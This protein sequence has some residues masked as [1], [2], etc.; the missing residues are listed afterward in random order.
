MDRVRTAEMS[1]RQVDEAI[2]RGAAAILPL[3]S[4]E[5]HGPHAATGDYLI[6]EEV[7]VRAARRSGDVVF[8]CLPFGYSEYFRHFP[9]TVTLQSETL[10]RVVQDVVCC[11]MD[12]GF[13]H[14]V[15]LNGHKGNEPALGDLIRKLRRD[16]GLLVPVASPLGLGLTP[17]LT[18]E[19]YGE[20]KIGHGGE[21]M[22]SLWMYLFPGTVD[23]SLAEDWG[24]LDFLGLDPSG[25]AGVR[26][27]GCEVRFA[28][29]MDDITPPSG[30]LSNPLLASA[31]RGE[32]IV[33]QAVGRLV[34][35]MEW[36][37]GVDPR[38]EPG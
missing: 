14:I 4:T 30:S 19:L 27:E 28:V 24:T 26:F 12:Q 6:A 11:L 15:I 37:K 33:D 36:F 13:S 31:E 9:G 8:P 5:E 32:R 21:P 29:D 23:L 38:V 35:F 10:F 18:K 25:L 3:G 2:K 16:R 1:W 17:E 34:R 7:A 22:G 20:A